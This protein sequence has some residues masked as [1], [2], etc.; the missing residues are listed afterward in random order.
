MNATVTEE[1]TVRRELLLV[2]V[3][4]APPLGAGWVRLTVHVMDALDPTLAGLQ[5][6]NE[7]ST[8]DPRFTV[9]LAELL[10]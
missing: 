4:E 2:K 7:T 3:I 5:S 1:G 6:T 9:V 8:E 10:L